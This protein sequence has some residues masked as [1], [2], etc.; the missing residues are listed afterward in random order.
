MIGMYQGTQTDS[1]SE[2][3]TN[4]PSYVYRHMQ[5]S[6]ADWFFRCPARHYCNAHTN[7]I[8]QWY[9]RTDDPFNDLVV[10]IFMALYI[11][12]AHRRLTP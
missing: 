8:L 3:Y 6:K 12:N 2:W 10:A 9:H 1:L 7:F 11:P 4:S 5:K